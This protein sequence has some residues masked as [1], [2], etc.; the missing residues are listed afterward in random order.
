[1]EAR[2]IRIPDNG[3]TGSRHLGGSLERVQAGGSPLSDPVVSQPLAP[4]TWVPGRQRALRAIEATAAKRVR[5]GF[6]LRATL[7]DRW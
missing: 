3:K 7:P 5:R 2:Y 1:M 4:T 6:R